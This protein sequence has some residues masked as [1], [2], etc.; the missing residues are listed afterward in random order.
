MPDLP[1]AMQCHDFAQ[2]DSQHAPGNW[3]ERLA[4]AT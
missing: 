1:D 4:P 2:A 3:F